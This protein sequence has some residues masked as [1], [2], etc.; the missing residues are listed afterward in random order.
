MLHPALS[1]NSVAVITGGASGVGLA[2]ATRFVLQG[3]RVCIADLGE[4]K[5]A[6]AAHVLGKASPIGADAVMT[7]VTD[8]SDFSAMRN[9]E[10]AVRERFGVPD[11]LVNN[12]GIQIH[13][14]LLGPRLRRAASNPEGCLFSGCFGTPRML[15]KSLH[16]VVH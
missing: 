2:A 4:E 13:T 6:R 9:L 15:R 7:S 10:T 1:A 11:V 16:S 3:M 5:M 14:D 8:V 12:A